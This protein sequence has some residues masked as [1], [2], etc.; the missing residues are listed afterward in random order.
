MLLFSEYI[1]G[2]S[3]NKALEIVNA[4]HGPADLSRCSLRL[5]SNSATSPTFDYTMT[6][7][8]AAGSAYVICNPSIVVGAGRC[9]AMTGGVNHNGNDSYDLQCDGAVVDS[10]GQTG[11]M[12]S[13]WT[14]GGLG[15]VD[16]VLRRRCSVSAGDPNVTDAF[17]P[18]T[19]WMGMAYVD[20]TAS[21][22]GLGSRAECP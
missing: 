20:P 1:E 19:Q 6:G 22:S 17:D 13:E 15:T 8:L 2:T 9:D 12:V 21:H 3:N 5:Y 14:G 18:S 4:G 11:T 10:F 16:F 7:T